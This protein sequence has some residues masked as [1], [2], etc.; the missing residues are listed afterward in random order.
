MSVIPAVRLRGHPCLMVVPHR[1]VNRIETGTAGRVNPGKARPKSKR[2][3]G[4]P[5]RSPSA[6]FLRVSVADELP[7]P[8]LEHER[9]A[10]LSWRRRKLDGQRVG[11]RYIYGAAEGVKSTDDG[12]LDRKKYLA[13]GDVEIRGCWC[14]R[15]D[16]V[17]DGA[18]RIWQLLPLFDVG[19][20]WG[21]FAHDRRGVP[22]EPTLSGKFE[23]GC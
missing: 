1:V 3:S 19:A 22:H 16:E 21:E 15:G 4:P 20:A 11:C 14:V 2:W 9:F 17:G 10:N 6:G 13:A 5:G 23:T 7:G 18:D 8:I 12:A